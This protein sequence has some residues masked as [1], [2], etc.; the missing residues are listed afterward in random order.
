MLILQGSTILWRRISFNWRERIPWLWAL[1]KRS[2]SLEVLSEWYIEYLRRWPVEQTSLQFTTLSCEIQRWHQCLSEYLVSEF[3]F[4]TRQTITAW[5][6]L[7][8]CRCWTIRLTSWK[9]NHLNVLTLRSRERT[10]NAKCLSMLANIKSLQV[11]S[12][13]SLFWSNRWLSL[14][15]VQIWSS[16]LMKKGS[17]T[18]LLKHLRRWIL[19]LSWNQTLR[20]KSSSDFCPI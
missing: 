11:W 15:N 4:Q 9:P 20:R 14:A 2:I 8:G 10:S 17:L 6:I 18:L 12:L 5:S 13:W 7:Q 19:Q 3:R 16:F 1:C